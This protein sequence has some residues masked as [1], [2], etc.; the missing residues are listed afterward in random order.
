LCDADDGKQDERNTHFTLFEFK[1]V[2]RKTSKK[3]MSEKE[4][5]KLIERGSVL[6]PCEYKRR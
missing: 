3:E 1:K 5:K 4:W 2:A 6:K